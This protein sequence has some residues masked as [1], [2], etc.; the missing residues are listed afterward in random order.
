VP[1]AEDAPADPVRFE[2]ARSSPV[3]PEA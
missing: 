2:R 1:G 3:P